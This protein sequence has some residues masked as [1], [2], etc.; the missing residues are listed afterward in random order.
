MGRF[1]WLP[2]LRSR[3]TCYQQSVGRQ[4]AYWEGTHDGYEHL[5][6]PTTHRRGILHLGEG[7][8]LVLD[9]LNSVAVHRYRLHWLLP[10]V[11]HEWDEA[12]GHIRL[13]TPVGPYHVHVGLWSEEEVAAT[14]SLVEADPSSPRGWYAPYYYSREPALSLVLQTQQSS[15]C[16]WTLFGP[17]PATI[18]TSELLLEIESVRQRIAI[19]VREAAGQRLVASVSCRGAI[20]DQLEV[21]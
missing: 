2:W 3:V 1:L 14:F 5:P 13:D 4:L 16:S 11:S 8:W 18:R 10:C 15:F 21:N 12:A 19:R 6:V 7:W 9:R 20:E 17:E